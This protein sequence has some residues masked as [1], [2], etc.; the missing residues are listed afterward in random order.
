MRQQRIAVLLITLL[1][2]LAACNDPKSKLIGTWRMN[3]EVLQWPGEIQLQ[4]NNDGK[5]RATK[6]APT[7]PPNIQEFNN[8]I[9]TG[10][11]DLTKQG[12]RIVFEFDVVSEG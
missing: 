12:D 9:H 5:F 10:H 3:I 4:L 1:V 8:K 11:W 7:A 2:P 6:S